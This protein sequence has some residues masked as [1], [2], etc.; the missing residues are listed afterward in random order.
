MKT[1]TRILIADD[2]PLLREALCRVFSGQK[3]IQVV[4][5]AC[6][7]EEVVTLATRMRPDVVVMDVMMPKADGL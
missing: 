2:H 1:K 5:E 4:G 3:D 7:G 6:D